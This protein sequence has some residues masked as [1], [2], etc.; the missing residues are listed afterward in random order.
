VGRVGVNVA[1]ITLDRQGL[2]K[3]DTEL[4]VFYRI[5]AVTVGSHQAALIAMAKV[6]EHMRAEGMSHFLILQTTAT[7]LLGNDF[8][9]LPAGRKTSWYRQCAEVHAFCECGPPLELDGTFN[10]QY[11]HLQTDISTPPLEETADEGMGPWAGPDDRVRQIEAFV[12]DVQNLSVMQRDIIPH[13][14]ARVKQVRDAERRGELTSGAPASAAWRNFAYHLGSWLLR[15]ELVLTRPLGAA[16]HHSHSVPGTDSTA[17]FIRDEDTIWNMINGGGKTMSEYIHFM[18]NHASGTWSPREVMHDL[19]IRLVTKTLSRDE[20][21]QAW[22][23]MEAKIINAGREAH[24]QNE[25]DLERGNASNQRKI[26]REKHQPDLMNGRPCHPDSPPA[27]SSEETR[28]C[29]GVETVHAPRDGRYTLEPERERNSLARHEQ[30]ARGDAP[31]PQTR[32]CPQRPSRRVV[33]P[34]PIRPRRIDPRPEPGEQDAPPLVSTRTRPPDPRLRQTRENGR[35]VTNLATTSSDDEDEAGNNTAVGA[36]PR[37]DTNS[38]PSSADDVTPT[39]QPWRLAEEDGYR[40]R[41][42]HRDGRPARADMSSHPDRQER[43]ERRPEPRPNIEASRAQS[44][45]RS[46]SRSPTRELYKTESRAPLGTR[47]T[48]SPHEYQDSNRMGAVPD[49]Y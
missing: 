26:E 35:N 17:A 41:P 11:T 20:P 31:P 10:E 46:R 27:L 28:L 36:G 22:G 9:H 19:R 43:R 14:A 33:P 7:S 39:G 4:F 18:G 25:L 1:R 12:E 47:A 21:P 49:G 45:A 16:Q 40:P 8:S 37:T 5:I 48:T 30:A 44:Y 32:Q 24:V 29:Q 13:P 38:Y 42:L 2:I 3:S 34:G 6:P 15:N 23:P